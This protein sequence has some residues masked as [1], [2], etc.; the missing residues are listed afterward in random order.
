MYIYLLIGVIYTVLSLFIVK[1]EIL[2]KVNEGPCPNITLWMTAIMVVVV[3]P[4]CMYIGI[5][6]IIDKES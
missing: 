3:W 6:T 2:D 4:Y 5:K 1:E